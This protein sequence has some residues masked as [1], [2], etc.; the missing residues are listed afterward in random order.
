MGNVI[1]TFKIMPENLETDLKKAEGEI[2][3]LIEYYGGKIGKVEV[4]EVAF[5]L[6][7]LK[8]IMIA[9]ENKGGIQELEDNIRNIDGVGNVEITD[10]RRAIG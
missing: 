5:G 1:V 9:D 3:K 2:V 6:K 10:V 7:S 8:I 4:E